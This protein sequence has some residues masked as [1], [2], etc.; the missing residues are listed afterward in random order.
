[1]QNVLNS[2]LQQTSTTAHQALQGDV[3]LGTDFKQKHGG[4][5]GRNAHPQQALGCGGVQLGTGSHRLVTNIETI[6]SFQ[7]QTHQVIHSQTEQN[8]YR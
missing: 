6:K 8:K 4:F 7:V 2:V 5:T 3:A 1:M